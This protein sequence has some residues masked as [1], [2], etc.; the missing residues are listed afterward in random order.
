ML[1]ALDLIPHLQNKRI[2]I[3]DLDGTL[4]N[5]SHTISAQNINDC[6]HLQ[7]QQNYF[8]ILAT[9]RNF[10][11][12]LTYALQLKMDVYDGYIVCLAGSIVYSC[13]QHKMIFNKPFTYFDVWKLQLLA[14]KNQQNYILCTKKQYFANY[15][16]PFSRT[17]LK[18]LELN[19][20]R[21]IIV[22]PNLARI[23]N[24]KVY[25]IIMLNTSLTWTKQTNQQMKDFLGDQYHYSIFLNRIFEITPKDCD[26][27]HGIGLII[28]QYNK[29]Y[30]LNL[31]F[32]NAIGFGDSMNDFDFLK[33]VG[34]AVCP[35]NAI[36]EVKKVAHY[37]VPDRI[38]NIAN[39]LLTK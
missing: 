19:F 28:K 6:I 1:N 5:H 17:V 8:L 15:G 2:I 38:N 30:K 21:N 25:K 26:K 31:T 16:T 34:L 12:A 7:A 24:R 13:R 37:I 29:Q 18:I 20:N 9:G 27:L 14:R 10:A 4:L 3:F 33:A 39:F 11:D 32:A 22:L 23:I 35:H 36:A